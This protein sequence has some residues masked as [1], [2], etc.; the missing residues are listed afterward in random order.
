MK[1]KNENNLDRG[2]ERLNKII[3]KS[4]FK[5]LHLKKSNMSTGLLLQLNYW[6]NVLVALDTSMHLDFVLHLDGLQVF[7]TRWEHTL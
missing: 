2:R 7:N 1:V 6:L 4:T 3:G 5:T